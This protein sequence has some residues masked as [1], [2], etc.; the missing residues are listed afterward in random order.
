[1]VDYK[2]KDK[3]VQTTSEQQSKR[4][5][6]SMYAINFQIFLSV[7]KDEATG[8]HCAKSTTYDVARTNSY[9]HDGV[10]I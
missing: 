6:R 2:L 4:K 1:M 9:R 3:L 7:P 5:E 8:S 10:R